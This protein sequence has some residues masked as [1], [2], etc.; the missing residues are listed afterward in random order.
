M[1]NLNDF[2][3]AEGRIR[4]LLDSWGYVTPEMLTE[5]AAESRV[6]L[7]EEYYRRNLATEPVIMQGNTLVKPSTTGSPA[8]EA[9]WSMGPGEYVKAASSEPPAVKGVAPSVSTKA[10]GSAESGAA[11]Q[12]GSSA[13]LV[14]VLGVVGVVFCP[15]AAIPAWL[16]GARERKKIARGESPAANAALATAGWIMGIIGTALLVLV[17]GV[18]VIAV[19]HDSGVLR[20]LR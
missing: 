20:G 1:D 3:A 2:G 8:A 7:L 17:A 12:A 18:L 6:R 15:L 19:V 16:L 9:V 10:A 5:Q 14:L 11:K 13:A 4:L